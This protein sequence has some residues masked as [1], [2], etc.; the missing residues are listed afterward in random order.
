MPTAPA[1]A[2]GKLH[3]QTTGLYFIEDV[4]G[5]KADIGH[6]FFGEQNSGDVWVPP[7]GLV[8]A[9]AL[10][11]PIS[12]N[13]PATPSAATAPLRPSLLLEIRLSPDMGFLQSLFDLA[14]MALAAASL[15]NRHATI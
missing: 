3:T 8:Q 9:D 11:G 7:A 12:Y 15:R 5:R 13:A 1:F 14:A 10:R 4:K 6:F 2:G